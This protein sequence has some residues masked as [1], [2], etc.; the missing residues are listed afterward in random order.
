MRDRPKLISG[1]SRITEVA[2]GARHSV[3]LSE[4]R[5]VYA[6]GEAKQG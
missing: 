5:K 1:L 3:F 6:C 2:A 4:S